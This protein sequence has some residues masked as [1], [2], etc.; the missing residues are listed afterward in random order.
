MSYSN[1]S[2]LS[3]TSI[4]IKIRG[5]H[6]SDFLHFLLKAISF[7]L[8]GMDR[9]LLHCLTN[10]IV[11]HVWFP[12]ILSLLYAFGIWLEKLGKVADIHDMTQHGRK[13]DALKK[14]WSV[15]SVDNDQKRTSRNRN[16]GRR[17]VELVTGIT[18]W[19]NFGFQVVVVLA[20]WYPPSVL[21]LGAILWSFRSYN[22][23]FLLLLLFYTFFS[24]RFLV[25][26]LIKLY[27]TL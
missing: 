3:N 13:S 27:E 18:I 19:V 7:L 20:N 10:K 11:S 14:E 23:L 8:G 9:L 24:A 4:M 26:A 15:Y 1:W 2:F 17:G 21:E 5:E 16:E 25:D 12:S 6:M 22:I